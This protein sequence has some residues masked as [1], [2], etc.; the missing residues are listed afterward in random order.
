MATGRTPRLIVAEPPRHGK[1]ELISRYLPSWYLGTFPDRRVALL[2]Y[3]AEFAARW[4]RRARDLLEEHGPQLF[5]ARV[6]QDSRAAHEWEL[7][8]AA[9]GM[10]T[11]GVGGPITGKGA[12]LMIVDDPVKNAEEAQS[13]TY[14]EKAWDWWT[15]TA[16]TRLE[17]GG[18][19]IVVMTRWH[20]DDLVGRI[21]AQARGGGERWDVVTLPA[22]AEENDPLGRTPGEALWP[23][24]YPRERLLEIE[25]AVGPYVW[26]ALYQQRPAPREGGMFKVERIKI[27]QAAVDLLPQRVRFWDKAG[28]ADGG[29]Y[30]AGVLMGRDRERRYW[31]LD[32]V[33]GQWDSA[34]RERVI[35]QTAEAD[36][37]EVK[38]GIEQEP[39]SGGKES[40]QNTIR[41]LAG[42][43]CRA[44]RPTGDKVLRADPFSVQVNSENVF[45]APGNWNRAYLDELQ[46]F[47]HF[48]RGALKD[49]V[50]A[51]S[52]AFGMLTRW[53]PT[54]GAFTGE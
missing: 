24:R 18:S 6:R 30:T 32:V 40:A 39:G 23:S 49:Q 44:E 47:P 8:G 1:S 26:S 35:R 33:R 19:V 29:A 17:P 11:A 31:V 20:E 21:L 53:K 4:G 36:G 5:G 14:R 12:D 10:T 54:L 50:D 3:E 7:A 43:V 13:K 46:H 52:G 51:S 22:L 16:Y 34:E 9:G 38:I 28:T 2:S 37:V 45:L 15:S 41:N 42:F 25:R 27:R 48:P